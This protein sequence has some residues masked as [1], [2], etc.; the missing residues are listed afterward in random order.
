MGQYTDPMSHLPI[1]LDEALMEHHFAP[2]LLIDSD[3][4]FSYLIGRYVERSGHTFAHS[5]GANALSAV[6]SLQPAVIVIGAPAPA[7]WDLLRQLRTDGRTRAIPLVLCSALVDQ[8]R[9]WREGAIVC[10]AKPVM[11]DDFLAALASV[12]VPVPAES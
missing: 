1:A 12:G 8:E 3:P 9:A 7:S 4:A 6:M 2:V 11:Y 10:L 5:N